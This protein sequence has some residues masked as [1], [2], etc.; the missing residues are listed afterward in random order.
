MSLSLREALLLSKKKDISMS[1]LFFVLTVLRDNCL[2][3]QIHE[4]LNNLV[5]NSQIN[6]G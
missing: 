1:E 4:I 2:D 3:D 5:V 6:K